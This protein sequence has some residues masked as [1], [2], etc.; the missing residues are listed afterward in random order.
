MRAGLRAC[1]IASFLLPI[2]VC[3][4]IWGQSGFFAISSALSLVC[5]CVGAQ[6][7]CDFKR[8]ISRNAVFQRFSGILPMIANNERSPM[9]QPHAPVLPLPVQFRSTPPITLCVSH[10]TATTPSPRNPKFQPWANIAH[11]RCSP[12]AFNPIFRTL[13]QN[14]Q[15]L[16][17][18]KISNAAKRIYGVVEFIYYAIVD[19]REIPFTRHGK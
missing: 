6:F 1:T 11:V 18:P 5:I 2:T 3:I 16:A 12:W 15:N 13:Y 8:F 17:D 7:I 14:R 4:C 10:Y 9:P 19:G